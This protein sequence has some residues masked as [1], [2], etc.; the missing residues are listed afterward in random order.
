M[1]GFITVV[2]FL[3][4]VSCAVAA[5]AF[6]ERQ[7][8]LDAALA[9]V[10]GVMV[11]GG[12]LARST[13]LK[14]R[15][16]NTEWNY[17]II[18]DDTSRVPY[19]SMCIS[20]V[21]LLIHY[22]VE[23]KI[24]YQKYYWPIVGI[25]ISSV[26]VLM[27]P[28]IR[29]ITWT[30]PGRTHLIVGSVV[31]LLF[32]WLRA[33]NL[34]FIPP[35]VN[36]D[37]G[38]IGLLAQD[39]AGGKQK[40]FFDSGWYK[41]PNFCFGPPALTQA[42]F[43]H[44]LFG[45]R[46]SSTIMGT[47]SLLGLY[48]LANLLFGRTLAII[49]LAFCGFSYSHMHFSRFA[50]PFIYP[51]TF[52]TFIAYFLFRGLRGKQY[53][54][55]TAAGFLTGISLMTYQAAR[56]LPLVVITFL[57]AYLFFSK[58]RKSAARVILIYS[59]ACI[60]GMGPLLTMI[61]QDFQGY[62]LR[63]S[64]INPFE[65]A[66][67]EHASRAY[68]TDSKWD[69]LKI[70]TNQTLG[71]FNI[72]YDKSTKFGFKRPLLDPFSAMMLIL[73]LGVII[74]YIHAPPVLFMLIWILAILAGGGIMTI[75]A[76]F[77]LRLIGVIPPV[78]ILIGIIPAA[79]YRSF[80]SR[81]I[82]KKLYLP[83][84]FIGLLI[85]LICWYNMTLYF[86]KY[87]RE[88]PMDSTTAIGH[89]IDQA[90][91]D[92]SYY[93]LT[94][95]HFYYGH[96]GIR[97]VSKDKGRKYNFADP[98]RTL[99][100]NDPLLDAAIIISPQYRLLLPFFQTIFPQGNLEEHKVSNRILFFSL[101]VDWFYP[102]MGDE[103]LART[104]SIKKEK[105]WVVTHTDTVNSILYNH[106]REYGNVNINERVVWKGAIRF[107]DPGSYLFYTLI[108][109]KG[110]WSMSIDGNAVNDSK[111]TVDESMIGW[112]R[113]TL[114]YDTPSFPEWF[115]FGWKIPGARVG[116]IPPEYLRNNIPD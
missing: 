65:G 111:F 98:C 39:I 89:L 59:I 92:Y 55:L 14:P 63:H 45:L 4:T 11:I 110:S 17:F 64:L 42:I 16:R 104:R 115:W 74:I 61:F 5:Q 48:L 81:S 90:G 44:N 86:G 87:L 7:T 10:M 78:S 43:G 76:P 66:G 50:G 28:A 21:L 75:N 108:P 113:F 49:A 56:V 88:N 69:I 31:F 99:C 83:E 116:I 34:E 15:F 102:E 24:G 19:I 29:R 35:V 60:I 91:A 46:I 94:A 6:F 30:A 103:C 96:Q 25:W 71:S 72:Y 95:P 105:E 8:N 79:L 1:K 22:S 23:Y 51:L 82:L 53:P 62:M 77:S 57:A 47:L 109:V 84:L 93:F 36:V 58:T 13:V 106:G 3:I 73:S 54:N 101:Y 52:G 80:K 41:L 112:H 68:K 33:F 12:I 85:V 18:G 40:L 32:L 67:Y 26:I 37:E 100:G 27:V 2:L 97:F 9:F 20:L 38:V 114:A 70:Q 107:P